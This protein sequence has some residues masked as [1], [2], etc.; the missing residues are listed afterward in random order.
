MKG[1]WGCGEKKHESR[2]SGRDVVI[3]VFSGLLV[4]TSYAPVV[5]L[6]PHDTHI[7][8]LHVA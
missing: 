1:R 6:T 2:V 8:S 4:Q 3:L 7:A 5:I